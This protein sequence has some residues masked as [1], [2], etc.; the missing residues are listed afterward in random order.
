MFQG[1]VRFLCV[2]R[3]SY[4]RGSLAFDLTVR[5]RKHNAGKLCKFNVTVSPEIGPI[6]EI[7]SRISRSPAS[8]F[9][10]GRKRHDSIHIVPSVTYLFQ[11]LPHFIFK[12]TVFVF[13]M[14]LARDTPGFVENSLVLYRASAIMKRI[15]STIRTISLL[16]TETDE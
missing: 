8:I 1:E 16:L 14:A 12:E 3:H 10:R 9:S 15:P 5:P 6:K 2:Q 13:D 11:L 4:V 7:V